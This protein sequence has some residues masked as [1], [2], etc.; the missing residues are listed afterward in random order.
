MTATELTKYEMFLQNPSLYV[1]KCSNGFG[2]IWTIDKNK[3][4][5]KTVSWNSILLKMFDELL[6]NA[7]D[8]F[9]CKVPMTFINCQFSPD[10]EKIVI[11]NNGK[12]ISLSKTKT[13]DGTVIFNPEL[14]FSR[15]FTSTH[16]SKKEE[17]TSGVMFFA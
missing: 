2:E 12:A 4:V 10:S 17:N 3:L 11:S 5:L 6:M 14:I 7:L 8:N 13:V 1:G 9:K 16:Y 15:L